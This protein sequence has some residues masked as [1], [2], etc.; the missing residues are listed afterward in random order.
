MR[1]PKVA[2]TGTLGVLGGHLA[3]RLELDDGCRRLL[4]LDLVP[5]PRG[6][7]KALY[8]RVDLTEPAVSVRI[9]EA[10]DR[11]RVDVLVHAAFLQHPIRNKSYEHELE[12]L[13][14]MHLLHA[15]TQ[16]GRRGVAPH[17]ILASSTLVYGARADNPSF[18]SE[19]APLAGRRDYPLVAEKIEAERQAERFHEQEGAAVTILRA[20]PILSP[21]VRTLAG[22]YL[23]LP[24][25]PTI[26]GFNPMIQTIAL[27]DATDAFARAILRADAVG[28]KGPLRV[29]NVCGDGV[30]PLHTATR[31]CGRRTLPLVRFAA[32]AMVDA[33]FEA[34]LAIA[35]SAHLDYLQYS[36]VA[37]GA[38]A[39]A[40]L[41]FVPRQST[42]DC[43]TGFARARV[44]DAA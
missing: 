38:R 30:M 26:L 18:L 17:L 28:P 31:L 25:A 21:E 35:P 5:P 8:Y 16:L 42:R 2:L 41:G 23:S 11:E 29:Y 10:L 6:L 40:E 27:A 13:G 37:D 24:A 20:A 1:R 15:L 33:L 7:K 44:R 19:D 43:M 39:R 36:C 32:N 22:R 34:G 4:L 3:R 14:T 12:S 9:A